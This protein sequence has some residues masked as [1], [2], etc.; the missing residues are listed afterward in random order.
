MLPETLISYESTQT[1]VNFR[2]YFR[3][4]QIHNLFYAC[5]ECLVN[6]VNRVKF[7]NCVLKPWY[8][9][10]LHCIICIGGSAKEQMHPVSPLIVCTVIAMWESEGRAVR[11]SKSQTKAR[12]RVWAGKPAKPNSQAGNITYPPLFLDQYD[13]LLDK[14]NG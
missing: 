5:N 6:K 2:Q 12:K 1:Y 4:I 9:V 10:S 11:H 3:T 14:G 13:L 8:H 7:I